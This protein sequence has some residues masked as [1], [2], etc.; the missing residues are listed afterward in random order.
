MSNLTPIDCRRAEEMLSDHHE[1]SLDGPLRADLETHL[2]GCAACRELSSALGDVIAALRASPVLEPPASLAERAASAALAARSVAIA[3][4]A[5]RLWRA[6]SLVQALAAGLAVIV[7]S[8]VLL[9]TGAVDE[10]RTASR[11]RERTVNTGAYLLERKDRLVEDFR[12]MRVVV[13]TAFGSRV[14]RVNDRVDDYR[15]L[16]ERKK[17][18]EP[19]QKKTNGLQM[20]PDLLAAGETQMSRT[21]EKSLS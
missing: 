5:R 15:R 3:A 20:E 8:V 18:N 9:A 10:G 4:S 21:C 1:G 14:D 6:P 16:L 17:A 19:E 7:T 2:A 12:L 13:G 11:L